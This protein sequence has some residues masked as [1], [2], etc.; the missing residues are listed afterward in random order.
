M[1][2]VVKILTRETYEAS[3]A[4]GVCVGLPIDTESGYVH[5]SGAHQVP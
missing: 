3:V 5:L 4:A 2:I 1:P